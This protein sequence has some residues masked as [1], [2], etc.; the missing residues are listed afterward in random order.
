MN[1]YIGYIISFIIGANIGALTMAFFVGCARQ[2]DIYDK[3]R[4]DRDE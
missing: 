4:G 1:N 2:N 3:G